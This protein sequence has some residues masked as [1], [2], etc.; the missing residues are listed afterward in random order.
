MR[1]AEDQKVVGSQTTV[2]KTAGGKIS[3]IVEAESIIVFVGLREQKIAF[4]INMSHNL[5]VILHD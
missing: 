5:N 3:V 2:D 1:R 4:F